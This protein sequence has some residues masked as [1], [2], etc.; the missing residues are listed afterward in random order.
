MSKSKSE[1]FGAPAKTYI[2]AKVA[3]I[4]TQEPNNGC[5]LNTSAMEW[6]N[7]NEADAIA[8]FEAET[9]FKVEHFGGANP[10]FFQF[11][12]FSGGSPDG[13]FTDLSAHV[14]VKC[15]FNSTEHY[16]HYL[17]ETPDEL[18]SYAPEYYWQ[19]QANSLFSKCERGFFV[20][21]DPRFATEQ[22]QIKILEVPITDEI[23]DLIKERISEAENQLRISI[24]LMS[25][26]KNIIICVEKQK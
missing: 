11:T 13:I 4:L 5:R 17:L 1:Y 14:E 20:S 2:K 8:R 23:K 19:I 16:E 9:G 21:Y 18:L 25:E 3:E 6:G 7:A 15:P 10:K 24:E 12:D 26:S 22:F